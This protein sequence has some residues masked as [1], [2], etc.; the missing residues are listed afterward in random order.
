MFAFNGEFDEYSAEIDG[1]LFLSEASEEDAP[2][3]AE[4][5]RALAEAY[6]ANERRIM[7]FIT[8]DDHFIAFFGEIDPDEAREALETP[9]IDL[10]LEQVSYMGGFDDDHMISFEYVGLFEE[11]LYI[12]IDG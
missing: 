7:E 4:Q 9:M 6:R 8:G 5:A 12:S 1:L 3:L 11:L 10:D 2:D